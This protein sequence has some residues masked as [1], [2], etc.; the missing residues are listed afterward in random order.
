MDGKR[1]M[2]LSYVSFNKQHFIGKLIKR[3]QNKSLIVLKETNMNNYN[4][5]QYP[6]IRP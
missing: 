1:S 2:Y 5:L 6:S 4:I 3:K